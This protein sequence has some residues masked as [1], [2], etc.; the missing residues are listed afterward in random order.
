MNPVSPDLR[1]AHYDA[2]TRVVVTEVATGN[3]A[4]EAPAVRLAFEF[5]EWRMTSHETRR[6]AFENARKI[7]PR[8]PAFQVTCFGT[9]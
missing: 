2:D 6:P 8:T 1:R 5:G 9:G 4:T 3:G 7:A